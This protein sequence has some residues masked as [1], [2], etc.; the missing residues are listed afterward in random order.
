[1]RLPT[2]LVLAVLIWSA[3]RYMPPYFLEMQKMDLEES[4]V[5][6]RNSQVNALMHVQTQAPPKSPSSSSKDLHFY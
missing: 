6:L 2:A 1:M 4:K 5:A 3:A